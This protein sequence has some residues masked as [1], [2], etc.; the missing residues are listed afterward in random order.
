KKLLPE[1]WERTSDDLKRVAGLRYHALTVDPGSDESGDKGARERA[2]DFLVQTGG[3]QF[4]PD[5]AR[6]SLYRRGARVLAEAKDASY[7]WEAETVA[8]KTLGQLGPHV[9][10]IAFEEVYQEIL[11]AWC[12][13]Y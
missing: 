13:N 2:L 5:A 9:P 7:G 11:A 4:I 8:A 10:S 6:A 3:V 1:V 12:G